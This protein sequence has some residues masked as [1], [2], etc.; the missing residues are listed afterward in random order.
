[1]EGKR[2]KLFYGWI[3]VAIGFISMALGYGVRYMYPVFFIELEEKFGWTRTQTYGSFSL[4]M[5]VYAF[6]APLAG[7]LF[8]R[9]GPRKLF[10]VAA[11]LI[12]LGLLGC[13]QISQLWHLYL[14]GGVL[15][16]LGMVSLGVA[17]HSALL[18]NWFVKNRGLV[19]GLAAAGLGFGGGFLPRI[20]Q[21][22]ISNYGFRWA[23]AL[24]GV[25]LFLIVAPPTALFQR[26]RPQDKGLLPD[27]E[28]PEREGTAVAPRPKLD[29]VVDRDWAETEWTL[30]RALRTRRFWFFFATKFLLLIGVYGVMMHEVAFAVDMGFSKTTASWAFGLT[31]F[32]GAFAK[33]LWGTMGD[34]IGREPTYS[35]TMFLASVAIL[36]LLSVREPSQVWFLYVAAGLYGLGY[37]AIVS[38]LAPTCADLFQGKSLGAIYGFSLVAAG[39]GGALGPFFSAY[40]FDTTGGYAPAFLVDLAAINLSSALMWVV[41][42]RKVRL[43]MGRAKA[44]ARE[45]ARI[46]LRE[47]EAG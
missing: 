26:H 1:M 47:G 45:R 14:F 38:I 25:G 41:A 33:I 42:P 13:S 29:M 37:G 9:F 43:V 17:P 40:I 46:V 6:A 21:W 10:P 19:I 35:F 23:Y 31:L 8:D 27:G 2:N 39:S 11:L 32:L 20:A 18:S 34:R 3:V 12:A 44:R 24:L 7:A 28:A 5:L 36:L 22:L 16:P 4:K 15:I 30:G